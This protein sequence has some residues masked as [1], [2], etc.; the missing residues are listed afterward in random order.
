MKHVRIWVWSLFGIVLCLSIALVLFRPHTRNGSLHA[1]WIGGVPADR[2]LVLSLSNSGPEG[3]LFE[4][5]C[6]LLIDPTRSGSWQAYPLNPSNWFTYG[7]FIGAGHQVTMR[8]SPPTSDV[9]ARVVLF[10]DPSPSDPSRPVGMFANL[11]TDL[12]IRP[13]PTVLRATSAPVV[14]P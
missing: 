12:G 9:P 10:Y 4:P 13:R 1:S 11:L 14:L 2:T 6:D 7:G 5:R 8:W 3:L